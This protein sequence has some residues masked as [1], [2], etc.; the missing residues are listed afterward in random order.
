MYDKKVGDFM[1]NT[2]ENF[3][4][5]TFIKLTNEHSF[6]FIILIFAIPFIIFAIFLDKIKI[7]FKSISCKIKNNINLKFQNN[8]HK[9]LSKNLNSKKIYKQIKKDIFK[10]LQLLPKNYWYEKDVC[11]TN[12]NEKIYFDYIVFS[13]S[14]ICPI[15]IE[16]TAGIISGTLNDK[17]LTHIINKTTQ[18]KIVNPIIKN[19]ERI[20]SFAS[21]L[22]LSKQT[23]LISPLIVFSDTCRLA[24]PY[25]LNLT[26]VS[27]LAQKISI[28]PNTGLTSKDII[29]FHKKIISNATRLYH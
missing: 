8:N 26:T 22:N 17:Y 12:Q 13:D 4:I 9:S 27:T 16:S 11:I 15:I 18:L 23:P 7:L 20:N 10:E 21:F 28:L 14:I 3:L 1:F 5:D 25:Q 2:I 6:I 29:T 19:C 24:I